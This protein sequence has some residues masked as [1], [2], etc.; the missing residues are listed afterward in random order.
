MITTSGTS[1]VVEN[2]VVEYSTEGG[3]TVRAVDG[4]SFEVAA[5]KRAALVGPSGC[6]KSSILSVLA[7][8]R[9]PS[10]GEV[11]LGGTDVLRTEDRKL[12]GLVPQHD[13]LLMWR[14]AVENV[15]LPM[16]LASWESDAQSQRAS[17]LLD[18]FG[19]SESVRCNLRDDGYAHGIDS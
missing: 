19:M 17:E 4:V 2:L 1:L 9:E 3:N 5:G 13:A 14:T 18:L 11:R 6:G 16:E 10:D 12:F 8:V 7:G 15:C